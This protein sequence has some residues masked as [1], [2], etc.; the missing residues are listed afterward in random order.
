MKFKDK[1]KANDLLRYA[2]KM[3]QGGCCKCPD[4]VRLSFVLRLKDDLAGMGAV[5]QVK[6]LQW[7]LHK[8]QQEFM[9]TTIKRKEVSKKTGG[10]VLVWY[11]NIP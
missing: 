9:T 2:I 8:F 11:R 7:H 1:D 5:W 6:C 3:C 4:N 10:D